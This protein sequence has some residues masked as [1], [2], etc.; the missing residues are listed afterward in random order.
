MG[1]ISTIQTMDNVV[2][3]YELANHSLQ[4]T[5]PTFSVFAAM[6]VT[7]REAAAV[8]ATGVVAAIDGNCTSAKELTVGLHSREQR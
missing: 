1:A 8:T 3:Q 7:L 4:Q 2:T 6:N 5:I